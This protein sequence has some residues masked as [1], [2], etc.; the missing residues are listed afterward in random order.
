MNIPCMIIIWTHSTGWGCNRTPCTLWST[1]NKLEIAIITIS[2]YLHIEI[3]ADFAIWSDFFHHEKKVDGWCDR[4][5]CVSS[6]HKKP[7]VT[8]FGRGGGR[9]LFDA[10]ARELRDEYIE[11]IY[12]I[13]NPQ[14]SRK[15]SGLRP[16]WKPE[17]CRHSGVKYPRYRKIQ[18]M[19][20]SIMP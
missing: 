15:Q 11:R 7:L 2:Q 17:I 19:I 8:L 16:G 1:Q 4:F 13:S 5:F 3:I 10:E 6:I 9:V 12:E 18:P 14:L 20:Y